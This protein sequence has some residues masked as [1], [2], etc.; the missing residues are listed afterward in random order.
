MHRARLVVELVMEAGDAVAQLVFVS[1]A[2][3]RGALLAQPVPQSLV[4]GWT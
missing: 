2:V 3:Q 1:V 4:R